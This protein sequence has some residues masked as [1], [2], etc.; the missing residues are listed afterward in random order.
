MLEIKN[1]TKK[2][3]KNVVI[4]NLSYKFIEGNIYIIKGENGSGKSTLF[5]ILAGIINKNSGYISSN[6]RINFLPERY[7]LPELISSKNFLNNI[8]DNNISI[9]MEKYQL[10]NKLIFSLSKGNIQKI[11]IIKTLY[12]DA[13]VYILDECLD[14][15]DKE[16]KEVVISDLLR[17]KNDNK[18]IILS[19]HENIDLNKL[20]PKILFLRDGKLYEN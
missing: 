10:K 3:A 6:L 1:L 15:I 5:K 7:A 2:Y 12:M 8:I 13:D 18:I 9:I 16:I 20:M 4:D 19:L 17:I 14:G 11:G